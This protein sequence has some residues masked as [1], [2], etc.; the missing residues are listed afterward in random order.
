MLQ[1]FPTGCL[2]D[3]VALVGQAALDVEVM[4]AEPT[5]RLPS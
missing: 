5:T 2:H 1:L 4:V 3:V